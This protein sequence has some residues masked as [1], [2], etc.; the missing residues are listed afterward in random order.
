MR[1]IKNADVVQETYY[2]TWRYRGRKPKVVTIHDAIFEDTRGSVSRFSPFIDKQTRVCNASYVVFDSITSQTKFASYHQW[3]AMY[4]VVYP[5]VTGG[6][7]EKLDDKKSRRRRSQNSFLYVGTR[8]GHKDY[9]TLLRGAEILAES[10]TDV[11]L[12]CAGGGPL[13]PDE[14][15]QN[16]HVRVTQEDLTDEE[17]AHAYSN[18]RATVVTSHAEGFG[19]PVL[20]SFSCGTEV[21]CSDIPIFRETARDLPH[22]FPP[23]NPRELA[24]I[25][26]TF[27]EQKPST[28][29]TTHRRARLIESVSQFTWNKMASDYAAVYRRVLKA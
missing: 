26:D 16:P 20:E 10:G 1:E 19:Y 18:A 25:L 11:N 29:K 8:G 27:V 23:G 9:K 12:L 3:G 13:R 21:I 2:T 28:P 14:I 6:S 22:Y 17:L 5:G 24:R 15:S 7:I 4:S